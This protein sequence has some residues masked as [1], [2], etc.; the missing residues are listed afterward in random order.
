MSWVKM[1]DA[2]KFLVYDINGTMHKPLQRGMLYYINKST[3]A[4]KQVDPLVPFTISFTLQGIAGITIGNMFAIDYL[5]DM[6]R[7]FALFQDS[8]VSGA[9]EYEKKRYFLAFFEE[10]MPLKR[11][12]F[13]AILKKSIKKQ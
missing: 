6:Y 1:T 11:Y 5:P 9:R 8:K 7:R 4:K 12:L 3:T 10:N 2:K 13:T